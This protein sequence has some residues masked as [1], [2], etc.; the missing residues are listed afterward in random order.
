MT[1]HRLIRIS[2]AAV[3]LV[4]LAGCYTVLRHP[5]G[6]DVMSSTNTAHDG[7]ASYGYRTCAD[8]HADADYY[9]PYY[10]YG[11]SHYRWNDYYGSPWWYDNDWWWHDDYDHGDPGD[12]GP[13]PE[14]GTRHL[15]GAGGWPTKGWGFGSSPAPDDPP[16]TPPQP[17]GQSSSGQPTT[18][19]QEPP[20]KPAKD[21]SDDDSDS[22]DSGLWKERKKGF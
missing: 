2:L 18:N 4:S 1:R 13:P 21:D 22:D 5:T 17:S 11:S 20:K 14:T 7:Y 10:R 8:C 6:G 9:H 3:L 12:P 15:W 19:N 16:R